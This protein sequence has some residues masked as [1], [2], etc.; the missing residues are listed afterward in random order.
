MKP[1]KPEMLPL[2]FEPARLRD[3]G[4]SARFLIGGIEDWKKSGGPVQSK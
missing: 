4:V 1:V 2:P 3:A